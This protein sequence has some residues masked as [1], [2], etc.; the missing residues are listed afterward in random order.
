MLLHLL[1]SKIHKATVT[2]ASVDYE[3]SLTIAEDLMEEAGLR[4]HEIGRA[5][6]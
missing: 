6:V 2:A 1:K 3:G 5:H 4:V